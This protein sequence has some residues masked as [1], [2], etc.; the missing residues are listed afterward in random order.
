M[1]LKTKLVV[2]AA[3]VTF[4]IVVALSAIFLAELLRQRVA[5]TAA[6]DDVMASLVRK[7][8]AQA[9]QDG[10][11]AAPPIDGSAAAL[12]EAVRHALKSHQP[13]T[14]TMDSLVRYSPQVEDVSVTNAEGVVLVSTDP[15]LEGKA[16]P[17]RESFEQVSK[18][19]VRTEAREVF[20]RGRVLD[21]RSPLARNGRPF[22]VVRLGVRSSFLRDN[23]EPYLRG[24]LLLALLGGG[25]T[26]LA[27]VVL[28]SVAL[29]PIEDITRRL[30]ALSAGEV[31]DESKD[32]V[33]R[34]EESID[35]LGLR[36]RT[37]EAGYTDL[38][39]NLGQMLDTLRDGVVLFTPE[40][41][42]AMVSD[43]VAHFVGAEKP[44]VGQE[45][46]ELFS[47]KTAL[48]AAVR[49]A[50]EHE[51][52]VVARTLRLEDGRE[53]E[54]S[55]D[56]IEDRTGKLV[57]TLLTLRD[58]GSAMRL[59]QEMEV[60]RRLAAVGRLTAGVGHEVKNPIN[61]MV[62]H[63]ELLRGKLSGEDAGAMRHVDVLA[64]EMAR[65]DRVV[66]TLADFTRPM[67]LNLVEMELTD[68]VDA[69]V[70]LTSADMALQG[71][72]V[73]VDAKP[74][75]VRADGQVLRQALLN[76]VLNGMQA[77][78][79][80]GQLRVAVRREQDCGVVEVLDQGQG[81]APDLLAKIFELYFTTKAKGSG[82]GLAMT[83]R[84]AQMH[85]GGVDA[86]NEPGAGAKFTLRLPA[87]DVRR[88]A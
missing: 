6:S 59:E 76:L 55:L 20:G 70:E 57:G 9:V 15:A 41:R 64:G 29:R 67:E 14:D 71:V 75:L 42:A 21:V 63:L 83:Y 18:A 48:G 22:L 88:A 2:A 39:T 45:L 10:L 40:R 78:P 47:A 27:A 54:F 7:M 43:A 19:G 1:R 82:I 68:V 44:R 52:K 34:A 77:M 17:A 5:Q 84:I 25:I 74:V 46:W 79:G 65:L 58:T 56:R 16:A 73:V 86:V 72:Q 33:A 85:G 13:L 30:E 49:A 35:R 37:T 80:G 36:M 50:F 81:I 31:D 24:A 4:A 62:V 66:T 38:Q 11:T 12:A 26:M 69:V 23:Y 60:S 32:A 3:A 87:V 8:S 28:A 61:A 53:I 51:A